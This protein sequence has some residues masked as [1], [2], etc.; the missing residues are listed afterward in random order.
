MHVYMKNDLSFQNDRVTSQALYTQ[1]KRLRKRNREQMNFAI[2][3]IFISYFTFELFKNGVNGVEGDVM[4][5]IGLH[6]RI[7]R[8]I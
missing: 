1:R 5:C 7:W 3:I 4:D 8:A 6:A 2:A